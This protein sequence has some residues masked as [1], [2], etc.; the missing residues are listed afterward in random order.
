MM[1]GFQAVSSNLGYAL[2]WL[3]LNFVIAM[4]LLKTITQKP[5]TAQ[6]GS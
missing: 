3:G 2:M 5:N 6:E 1:F 4:M